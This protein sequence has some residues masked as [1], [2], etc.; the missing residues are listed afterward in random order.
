MKNFA[1]EVCRQ[2]LDIDLVYLSRNKL[3]TS[4]ISQLRLS[5]SWCNNQRASSS[6]T[7]K[8]RVGVTLNLLLEFMSL[9]GYGQREDI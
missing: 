5:R 4:F 8:H 2:L 7:K 6:T 9:Q 3:S 1:I